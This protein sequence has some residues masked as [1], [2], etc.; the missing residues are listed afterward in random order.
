VPLARPISPNNY[1]FLKRDKINNKI[2]Q[3]EILDDY[4]ELKYYLNYEE[5]V[6]KKKLI[7]IQDCTDWLAYKQTRQKKS[8]ISTSNNNNN[9]NNN[10]NK[11]TLNNSGNVFRHY[12]AFV[13]KTTNPTHQST[14]FSTYFQ[15]N[16]ENDSNID[17]GQQ[18]L[19]KINMLLNRKSA[20]VKT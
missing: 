1:P 19:Y 5:T 2:N 16:Y 17:T 12:S 11:S 6:K 18:Q 3:N 13:Q 4:H 10:S 7:K 8:N 20:R 9:N 14:S 15:S